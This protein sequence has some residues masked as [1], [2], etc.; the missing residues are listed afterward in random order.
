MLTLQRDFSSHKAL[1]RLETKQFNS[2]NPWPRDNQGIFWELMLT[3]EN[4]NLSKLCLPVDTLS[5]DKLKTIQIVILHQN[6]K[7][8]TAQIVS[9]L[10][11]NGLKRLAPLQNQKSRF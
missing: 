4:K 3:G 7:F 2:K 11:I 6:Q 8:L 10:I 9:S 5:G 1:E